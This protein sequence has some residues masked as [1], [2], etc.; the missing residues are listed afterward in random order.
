MVDVGDRELRGGGAEKYILPSLRQTT[1]P[2]PGGEELIYTIY[3][4]LRF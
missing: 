2:N 4:G 3:R 1:Q